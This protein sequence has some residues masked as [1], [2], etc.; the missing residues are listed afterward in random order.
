MDDYE[1]IDDVGVAD[2]IINAKNQSVFH[3]INIYLK[4]P[5]NLQ[6]PFHAYTF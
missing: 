5:L 6:I 2:L 4:I 1:D 3:N